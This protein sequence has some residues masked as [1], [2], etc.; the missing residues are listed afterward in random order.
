[1]CVCVCV[2]VCVHACV[3]IVASFYVVECPKGDKGASSGLWFLGMWCVGVWVRGAVVCG[4]MVRLGVVSRAL[5]CGGVMFG[6]PPPPPPVCNPPTPLKPP[7]K[8]LAP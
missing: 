6:A 7:R 2:C 8:S 1:M 3:S 5:V 4:P